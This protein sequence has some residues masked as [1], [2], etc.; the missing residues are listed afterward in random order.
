MPI[1]ARVLVDW[2][3]SSVVLRTYL[4]SVPQI[5]LSITAGR[6]GQAW[7]GSHAP[8]RR[9]FLLCITAP[10]RIIC[11]FVGGDVNPIGAQIVSGCRYPYTFTSLRCGTRAP[12]STY[13]RASQLVELLSPITVMKTTS[14][15]FT[16]LP[17]QDQRQHHRRRPSCCVCGCAQSLSFRGTSCSMPSYPRHHV[18]ETSK[19][20][21]RPAQ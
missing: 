15:S 8:A 19:Q 20:P 18:I 11:L 1:I 12:V 2:L 6:T 9:A 3:D 7:Q 5:N 13:Q 14:P 17:S 21:R 16:S 10:L 4:H